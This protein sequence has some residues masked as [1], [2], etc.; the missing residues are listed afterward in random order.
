MEDIEVLVKKGIEAYKEGQR[1]EAQRLLTQA[2]E[3]DER[4]EKAW[5]WLSGAVDND[6][7]RRVCLENVLALNPDNAAARRGLAH[8]ITKEPEGQ[9]E[10][11]PPVDSAEPSLELSWGDEPDAGF[12]DMET[13]ETAE[14]DWSIPEPGEDDPPPPWHEE[15]GFGDEP[16]D[17]PPESEGQ[18]DFSFAD[19]PQDA[20]PESAAEAQID[21]NTSLDSLTSAWDDE[22]AFEPEDPDSAVESWS[23]SL[24]QAGL[25]PEPLAP[26]DAGHSFEQD[27]KENEVE[28][29]SDSLDQVEQEPELEAPWDQVQSF[30]Q[31][32]LPEEAESWGDEIA[33][34]DMEAEPLPPWEEGL[35]DEADEPELEPAM[36]AAD[37]SPA[38][39]SAPSRKARPRPAK[40][41]KPATKK[42]GDTILLIAAVGFLLVVCLVAAFAL[43]V[44]RLG[45]LTDVQGPAAAVPDESQAVLAVLRENLAAYNAED[46]DRYMRTIHPSS[47]GYSQTESALN[48]M[49]DLFDLTASWDRAQ[50]QEINSREAL[51]SFVLTT[52]KI[53]GPA[54]RDNTI[55]GVMTLRPDSGQWKIYNQRV[56]DIQYLN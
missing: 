15:V 42:G 35:P 55:E 11:E 20:L 39:G 18:I 13:A 40:K 45:Q 29:W 21:F 30:E 10:S 16:L 7:D 27:D 54:F 3:L 23:D 41:A 22:H 49:V 48:E 56:D 47:P 4:N 25:D 19:E 46:I 28:S 44:P 38:P 37:A 52:R 51:V 5:L 24:D 9:P 17:A 34:N 1:D 32:D 12:G 8:L 31:D 6:E 33:H 26:W 2:V 36:S 14:M 53:S 43:V 50:I